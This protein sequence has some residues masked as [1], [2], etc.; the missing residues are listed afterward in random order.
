MPPVEQ[1][2]VVR[3]ALD[4]NVF[5][6]DLIGRKRGH[7]GTAA[8]RIVDAV[9]SGTCAAGPV[10]LVTSVPII[11]NFENVLKRRLGY[12][13]SD[14]AERAWVLE[15]YTRQ[16]PMPSA[17]NVVVGSGYIPFATENEIRQAVVS[18]VGKA[19]AGKLFDEIRD[20]RYVLETALAGNADILVTSNIGDFCR[21][22]AVKFKRND[23]AV[24]P[25]ADRK[26]VIATPQFAAYWIGQGITPDADRLGRTDPHTQS[27]AVPPV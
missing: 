6:A 5:V 24:F 16:G 27:S 4:I 10:Q 21:G 17:P 14:A 8:M 23:V 2:R 1:E 25:L 19:A 22:P 15:E 18:H 7:T 13:E 11:S 12:S 26:L 3:L 9:R 20:D